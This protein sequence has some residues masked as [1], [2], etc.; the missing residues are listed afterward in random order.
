MGMAIKFSQ[1]ALLFLNEK[2]S[3]N[4]IIVIPY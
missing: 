4:E 2:K 1:K 3:F